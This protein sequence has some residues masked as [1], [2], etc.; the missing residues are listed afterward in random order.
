ME[1]TALGQTLR[2]SI[3]QAG[4]TLVESSAPSEMGTVAN[5]SKM[6][7]NISNPF[8]V[9]VKIAVATMEELEPAPGIR[10]SSNSSAELQ[11]DNEVVLE[12][13]KQNGWAL[14]CASAPGVNMSFVAWSHSES[15][16]RFVSSKC[17]DWV[18]CLC[19]ELCPSTLVR[20]DCVAL[21]KR[22]SGAAVARNAKVRF[23][24]GSMDS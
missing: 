21:S 4:P 11:G 1:Y 22:M 5:R 10:T 17:P 15:E 16:A 6:E 23:L 9:S 7:S 8:I 3:E 24:R 20:P 19:G 12:A 14:E 2:S 18:L 13:V